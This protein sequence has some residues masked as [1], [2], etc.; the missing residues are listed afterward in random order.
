MTKA[1]RSL[2][3]QQSSILFFGEGISTLTYAQLPQLIQLHE[4][5]TERE[6]ATSLLWHRLA[7]DSKNQAGAGLRA[8]TG[9]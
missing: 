7:P 5:Q 1:G 3:P 4:F 8:G 2:V 6:S 9:A